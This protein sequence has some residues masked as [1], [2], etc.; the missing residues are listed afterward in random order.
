MRIVVT[1]AAGFIGSH[2][3]EKLAN[4]GH[5]VIGIDSFNENYPASI[6]EQ[7]VIHMMRLGVKVERL[8]LVCDPL[9]IA[10]SNAGIVY[11]LAAQSGLSP[12][13]SPAIYQRTNS[14]ATEIL[15]KACSAIFCSYIN[16]FSICKKRYW[17]RNCCRQPHL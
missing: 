15:L 5:Q 3:C 10:L 11:H 9:Q 17:N 8:D 13:A 16:V 7:N 1:G 14:L 4:L 6:K 12:Q 2:L